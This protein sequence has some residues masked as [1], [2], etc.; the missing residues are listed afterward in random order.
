MSQQM[1]KEMDNKAPNQTM[2]P[3]KIYSN[4]DYQHI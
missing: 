3:A 4:Q 2:D 1:L